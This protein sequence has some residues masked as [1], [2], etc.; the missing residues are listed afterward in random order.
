MLERSFDIE[1]RLT[2]CRNKLWWLLSFF[3]KSS[4]STAIEENLEWSPEVGRSVANFPATPLTTQFPNLMTCIPL[5]LG[6]ESCSLGSVQPPNTISQA[7]TLQRSHSRF[8]TKGLN[9][10]KI[11]GGLLQLLF[12]LSICSMLYSFHVNDLLLKLLKDSYASILDLILLKSF[13]GRISEMIIINQLL[14]SL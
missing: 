10:T 4:F 7:C 6:V 8:P 12:T 11:Y 9:L 2:G 13:Q 5:D 1:E 14:G 3:S